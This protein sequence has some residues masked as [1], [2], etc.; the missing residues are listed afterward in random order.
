MRCPGGGHG[1]LR[2]YHHPGYR[3]AEASNKYFQFCM[4]I[5]EKNL[6]SLV[7]AHEKIMRWRDED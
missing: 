1:G 2:W 7:H 6:L 5:Y 3:L 4:K